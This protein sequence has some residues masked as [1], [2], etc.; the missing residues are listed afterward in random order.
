MQ[1]FGANEGRKK[2]RGSCTKRKVRV[3]EVQRSTRYLGSPKETKRETTTRRV[4]A[5]RSTKDTMANYSSSNTGNK[6]C[7]LAEEPTTF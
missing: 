2:L 1:Y 6:N 4:K 7:H 3:E 5:R